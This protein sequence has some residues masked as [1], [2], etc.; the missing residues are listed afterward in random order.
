MAIYC[1]G[2]YGATSQIEFDFIVEKYDY[3]FTYDGTTVYDNIILSE[4]DE[5]YYLSV[6]KISG[7]AD[8]PAITIFPNYHSI[9]K[10]GD[11]PNSIIRKRFR[12]TYI[13]KDKCPFSDNSIASP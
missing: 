4:T 3:S 11:A 9:V 7:S 12:S 8:N 10:K 13:E 1:F 2:R 5:L 6:C